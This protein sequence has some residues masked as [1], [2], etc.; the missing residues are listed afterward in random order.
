MKASRIAATSGPT[1]VA[2]ESSSPRTTLALA[3]SCPVRQSVGRRAECAGRNMVA[4]IVETTA[5]A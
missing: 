3:N 1:S 5:S 2:T 4:A